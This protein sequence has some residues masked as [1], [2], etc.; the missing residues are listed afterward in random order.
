MLDVLPGAVL[1]DPV[2]ESADPGAPLAPPDDDDLLR[3]RIEEELFRVGARGSLVGAQPTTL[4]K[5]LVWTFGPVHRALPM[6]LQLRVELDGGRLVTVDPEVG[7][8][9]QG[10]EKALEQVGFRAGC[11]VVARASPLSPVGHRLCWALAVERL[12]GV[13]DRVPKRAQLWRVAV[14]E[15]GRVADHLAVVAQPALAPASARVRR[16]LADAARDARGLVD[17]LVRSGAFSGIGGLAKPLHDDEATRIARELP[18]VLDVVRRA[19]STVAE[20]PALD[21][22]LEGLG[23]ITRAEAL[24][25]SLTGPA[26][27]ATGVADD[28]RKSDP[29]FAYDEIA[30]EVALAHG[31]CARCRGRVRLDEILHGGDAALR[32][33]ARL[34]SAP[35]E[36]LLDDPA[37]ADPLAPPP[38]TASA[39]LEL[40]SGE[41]SVTVVSDGTDKPRRA[42]LRGPSAALAAALPEILVGD[43]VD[44]VVPVLLGL[45][46]TGTEVDR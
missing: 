45:G 38:G 16:A 14:L 46:L 30:V 17:G 15:L 21:A 9:H 6:P 3:P 24:S 1:P 43:R 42:R 22:H 11:D 13:A 27:R 12:C 33:L 2:A 28:L 25:L 40:A 10:L 4:A 44:D 8:L 19:Q 37:L 35:P 18:R 36:V 26:L 7:F 31:G 5:H 23:R 34:A 32:A 39:S 20:S 29:V 41:L